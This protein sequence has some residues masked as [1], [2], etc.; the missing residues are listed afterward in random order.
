MAIDSSDVFSPI[1]RKQQAGDLAK[2]KGIMA[3]FSNT[4][5]FQFEAVR[6]FE[7]GADGKKKS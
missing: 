3:L 4:S 7:R 2:E 5:F 6:L 1:P